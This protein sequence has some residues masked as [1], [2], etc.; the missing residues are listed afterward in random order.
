MSVIFVLCLAV[1]L[2]S[3]TAVFALKNRN[4]KTPFPEYPVP[5]EGYPTQPSLTKV[6]K[7]RAQVYSIVSLVKGIV[8]RRT[9]A[10]SAPSL[11]AIPGPNEDWSENDQDAANNI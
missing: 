4:Q 8:K 3:A 1:L 11:T 6:R 5:T 7:P 9:S 2:A 10:G